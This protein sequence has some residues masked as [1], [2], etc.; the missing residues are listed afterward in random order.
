MLDP[1]CNVHIQYRPCTGSV[2]I[3]RLSW[4]IAFMAAVMFVFMIFASKFQLVLFTILFSY[5]KF[6]RIK[7][8][9]GFLYESEI[10]IFTKNFHTMLKTPLLE[11]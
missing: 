7:K 3:C 4:F 5:I 6:L 8:D 10:V 11:F 2:Y 1:F 9:E